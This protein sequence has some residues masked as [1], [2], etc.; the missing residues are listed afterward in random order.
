MREAQPAVEFIL[1]MVSRVDG[2]AAFARARR[3]TSLGHELVDDPVEEAAIVVALEAK[4]HK[5]SAGQWCL[6]W[7]QL[8][9]ERADRRVQHDL[10][11]RPRLVRVHGQR[12]HAYRVPE[13]TGFPTRMPGTRE[14]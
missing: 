1:E 10:P 5:I 2:L 4:L 12:G 13:G 6:L 14:A 11:V 9:V 7:P 8:D 3:I